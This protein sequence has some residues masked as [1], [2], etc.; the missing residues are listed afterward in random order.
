MS[1]FGWA[2]VNDVITGS[3]GTPGGSDKAIQFASG[4]TFSGSTNF[5]FDYTTNTVRLTGTLH[6]D[7]L[8]VSSSVIYKS[9]S[10]K[11]GDDSTDTHQFTGS[12][13]L[14]SSNIVGVGYVDFNTSSAIPSYNQGRLYYDTDTFDLAYYTP[15]TDVKIQIGQQTVVR[16]KNSSGLSISK[17]K[18]VHITGG[19]GDNP[20]INTASWDND[21]NSANTLGMTMNTINHDDFGYVIL[22]GVITGVNTDPATFTAGQVIYLSSSGDYTATTP[23]APKHTVRLG[24]VVRAHASVGSI[25]VKIDNGYEIGELHDVLITTPSD[26]DLLT[27]NSSSALWTN[28]KILTGSYTVN[29]TITATSASFLEYIQLGDNL[30]DQAYFN[31]SLK[32]NIQPA[33]T[34][35]VDLGGSSRYWRTGYIT[36]LSS[37]AISSSVSVYTSEVRAGSVIVNG[38]ISGSG[39]IN[40]AGLQIT[41]NSSFSSPITVTGTVSS[42]LGFQ[43][44]GPTT[45]GSSLDVNGTTTLKNGA[46]LTGT[47]T[48]TGGAVTVF[49]TISGS[50]LLG[51]GNSI[52]DINGANV[53]GV[54]DDWAIQFKDGA[55]GTLTGSSNLTFT[56]SVL[57]LTGNL[58]GTAAIKGGY[59]LYSSSVSIPNT[60]YFVGFYSNSGVLTASLLAANN[61]PQGQT[62]IFKDVGGYAGT[63]NILIKAS[64]SETIDGA[65]GVSLTANSSSVTLLSNGSNGF[66][67]VGIV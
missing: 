27:Y 50:S 63:N 37:S 59:S 45:L 3:G 28:G 34:N 36:T 20:L 26:G 19:V 14:S 30:S 23:V 55:T 38:N 58:Y 48:V 2:Y 22:N 10:T 49:G 35:D 57:Y 41:G 66:Y 65:S 51:N 39:N 62:L 5:T 1:R 46:F 4:S 25:F 40:G 6:A 11:F 15:V 52:V 43:T 8:I 53:N 12:L 64:G 54:G 17:G 42:S 16:V 18:L 29:G 31:A 24:E 44:A 21:T 47:L 32:T 67:I 7:T 9:G 61:Y 60:S 56:G 33:A 13:L